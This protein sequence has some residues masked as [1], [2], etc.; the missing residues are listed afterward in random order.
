MKK[1]SLEEALDLIID[2]IDKSNIDIVD[3][4]ELMINLKEFLNILSYEENI[5]ERQKMI[6]SLRY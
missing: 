2:S 5:N 6:K 4:V 3:K 1:E